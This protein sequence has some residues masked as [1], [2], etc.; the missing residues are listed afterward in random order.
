MQRGFGGNAKDCE[1]IT[2]WG[3]STKVEP[4]DL[5]PMYLTLSRQG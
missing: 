1:V 4:T 2:E 5:P 3:F